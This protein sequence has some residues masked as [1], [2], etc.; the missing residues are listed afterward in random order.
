MVDGRVAQEVGERLRSPPLQ[1]L[2]VLVED[3]DHLAGQVGRHPQYPLVAGNGGETI[4]GIGVDDGD[5]VGAAFRAEAAREVEMEEI[6]AAAV[7]R[8]QDRLEYVAVDAVHEVGSLARLL[9]PFEILPVVPYRTV[10]KR[11]L[12]AGTT[13][14]V[15]IREDEPGNPGSSPA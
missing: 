7:A 1:C 15:Q 11:R 13:S 10:M 6:L 2:S 12:G 3:W 5:H 14:I 8:P 4:R 9:H